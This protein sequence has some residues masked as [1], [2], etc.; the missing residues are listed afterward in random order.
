MFTFEVVP[1]GGESYE[2]VA[3]SRDVVVWERTGKG[4][5]LQQL[6]ENL[7]MSDLY[8][9]AHLAARRQGRFDG[10]LE[11]FIGSV[12]LNLDGAAEPEGPTRPGR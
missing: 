8:E 4:R 10:S 5:S 3:A 6:T 9:V 7:R 1:D 12:D 11:D 2:L